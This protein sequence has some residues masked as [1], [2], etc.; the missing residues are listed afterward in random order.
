V[1]QFGGKGVV[2]AGKGVSNNL[3]EYT[4]LCRALRELI[5]LGWNREEVIVRSDSQLLIMQ[6]SGLWR[7]KGGLYLPAYLEARELVKAFKSVRFE[8]VPRERNEEADALSRLA[9]EEYCREHGLEPKY[10]K[11]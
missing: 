2:G 5:A 11:G 3:S 4:A 7:V 1:K 9:Y 8:W 10:R 6:M